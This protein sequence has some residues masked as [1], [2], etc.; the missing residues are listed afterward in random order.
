MKKIIIVLMLLILAVPLSAQAHTGLSSSSPAEE[1]KVSEPLEEITLNFETQIEAGSTMVLEGAGQ[2]FTF[3]KIIVS[4]DTLQGLLSE[5]ELPN[6]AYSIQ[7]T[8]IGAD[9]HPIK[10][11]VRFEVELESNSAEPAIEESSVE[12]SIQVEIT[13]PSEKA[14]D[15]ETAAQQDGS[16]ESML[17]TVLIS[18]LVI[19]ISVI[20]YRIYKMKK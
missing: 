11:E 1:E 7:W 12:A 5:K 9:G 10:G 16:G 4:G 20:A 17:G 2:T 18:I 14:T 8:I 13:A 19:A 3:D 15:F 6:G